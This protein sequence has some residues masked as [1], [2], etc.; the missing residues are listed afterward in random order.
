MKCSAVNRYNVHS[1]HKRIEMH[2]HNESETLTRM[3]IM[4]EE[5]S[6]ALGFG[7]HALGFVL[8]HILSLYHIVG[9]TMCDVSTRATIFSHY[10]LEGG[11][12]IHSTYAATASLPWPLA[13]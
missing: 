8:P 1:V 12:P 13:L 6:A 2:C 7:F 3:L 4:V 5:R 9:D 10:H 11:G